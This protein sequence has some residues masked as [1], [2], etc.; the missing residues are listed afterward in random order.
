M[1]I[2]KSK[3]KEII[4]QELNFSDLINEEPPVRSETIKEEVKDIVEQSIQEAH[5]LAPLP[6]KPTLA[7][8]RE[9]PAFEGQIEAAVEKLWA[10]LHGDKYP[11]QPLKV[12]EDRL[13]MWERDALKTAERVEMWQE[14]VQQLRTKAGKGN[15]S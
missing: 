1:K 6:P 15:G 9:A 2:T 13:M 5:G 10:S 8:W 7:P 3:L 4:L 11:N 14:I 12:A